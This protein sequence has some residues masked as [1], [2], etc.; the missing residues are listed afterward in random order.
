MKIN[1]KEGYQGSFT[2]L[3]ERLYVDMSKK[4]FPEALFNY[5]KELHSYIQKVYE[6]NNQS[7][8]FTENITINTKEIPSSNKVIVAFSGGKDSLAVTLKL[9]ELGYEPILYH[10]KG[11]NR[12]YP[13]ELEF[14]K[15]L[16]EKL[17]LE[18]I[19][20]IIT[21]SG[22]CDYKE[23]PIK[24]QFILSNMVDYGISR[25]ITNF[26]MGNIKADILSTQS[27]DYNLSDGLELFEEIEGF[28][29]SYIPNFKIHTLLDTD[30]HSYKIIMNELELLKYVSSCILP[31]RFKK[32]AREANIRK[33]GDKVEF[34]NGRCGSCYKCA[35]EYIHIVLLQV[36]DKDEVYHKHCMKVLKKNL[37]QQFPSYSG[38]INSD[39]GI[40][41]AYI[42]LDSI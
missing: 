38:D 31:T 19:E 15:V 16:A 27:L 8:S 28:Y 22:K 25:G 37:Y 10:M 20:V 26:A 7:P 21:I 2:K 40:M 30:T 1:F 5:P 39:D 29:K 17:G 23:H 3:F 12:S 4:P 14:T 41:R 32:N 11:I 36:V 24:N 33:F 34:M 42:D 6:C 18:L 9:I 35:M 13:H